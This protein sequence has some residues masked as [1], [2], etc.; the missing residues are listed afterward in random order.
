MASLLT[1]GEVVKN[2]PANARDTGSV[3][4]SGRSPGEGS[5]TPVQYPCLENSMDRGSW[6]ATV[7]GVAKA[8]DTTERLSTHKLLTWGKQKHSAEPQV[9]MVQAHSLLESG[10]SIN[11]WEISMNSYQYPR[12]LVSQ[13]QIRTLSRLSVHVDWS[14][15]M[16]LTQC[17][18][19][20][21]ICI[22]AHS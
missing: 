12:S 13:I 3:P 1:A 5:S 15:T 2:P 7:C 8:L 18:Y 22:H 17:W 6:W 9:L 10:G 11:S 19:R 21:M 4:G 14:P 16:S 20:D